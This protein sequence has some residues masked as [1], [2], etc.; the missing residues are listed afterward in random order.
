MRTVTLWNTIGRGMALLW[1]EMKFVLQDVI[2]LYVFDQ[3]TLT[4]LRYNGDILAPNVRPFSGAVGDN[5][6]LMQDNARPHTAML[7]MHYLNQE[8]IE[9]MDWLARSPD[10]NPIIPI[11]HV[12]D[13]IYRRT[14]Q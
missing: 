10:L 3:S 4:A 2:D 8:G 11:E 7:V 1:F 5:F 6:I 12:W 13:Y 14:S 9:I